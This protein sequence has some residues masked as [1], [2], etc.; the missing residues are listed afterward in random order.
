MR[1]TPFRYLD[2]W[3]AI[4]RGWVAAS[5][6]WPPRDSL[7]SSSVLSSCSSSSR[8][9]YPH[10]APDT[11]LPFPGRVVLHCRLPFGKRRNVKITFHG[12]LQ[13]LGSIKDRPLCNLHT[14]VFRAKKSDHPVTNNSCFRKAY[15]GALFSRNS[16]RGRL[17]QQLTNFQKNVF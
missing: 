12:N 3:T 10:L 16:D 14:F 15:R 4:C 7:C 2:L 17:I 5:S 6:S 13:S 1:K 11:D 8:R 9:R